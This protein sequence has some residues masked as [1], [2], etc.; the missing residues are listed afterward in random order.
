[1]SLLATRFD[2]SVGHPVGTYLYH[3]KVKLLQNIWKVVFNFM[4]N[5]I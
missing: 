1:M 4:P 5:I 3:Y 2:S